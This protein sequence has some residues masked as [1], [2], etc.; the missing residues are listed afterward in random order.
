[1]QARAAFIGLGIMGAPMAGHLLAAGVPLVVNTRTRAKA[2]DLLS[3][4]ARWAP[5]P[6]A[7]AAEADVVFICVPDTPDVESV[8][9][10]RDGVLSAVREGLLV[11]DHSTISPAATR[12]MAEALA[13]RGARLLDAP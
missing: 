12:R 6:A 7:A 5:T 3:R 1:M 11:V 13:A 2:G 9:Q 10:G 4:G 8:I